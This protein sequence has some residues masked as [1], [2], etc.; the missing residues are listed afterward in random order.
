MPTNSSTALQ[1]DPRRRHLYRLQEF[2]DCIYVVSIERNAA[3][4]E[5]LERDL[6][7]LSLTY[8]P[9]VDGH[10]L[11]AEQISEDYDEELAKSSY[12]RALSVGQLGCSLSHRQ[13]HADMVRRGLDNALIIEDDAVPCLDSLAAIDPM[14]AQLPDDWDFLYLFTSRKAETPW[15]WKKVDYLYPLLNRTG[16]R[17]YDMAKVRKSY[18]RAFSPNLRIAGQHWQTLSYALTRRTAERMLEI[19]TPVRAV[20]DDL[21]RAICATDGIRAFL[22]EPNIFMPR[23]GLDSTIWNRPAKPE[24]QGRP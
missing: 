21:T 19:Q 6:E 12:G 15:L 2:F 3:R 20:A 22:A 17:K 13:I 9:G 5:M 23:P 7:G 10:R 16:I 24:L 14:L 1:A 4:R 11:S 8:I 18:S